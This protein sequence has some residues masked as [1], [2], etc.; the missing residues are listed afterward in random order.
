MKIKK[1]YSPIHLLTYSPKNG[2][3]IIEVVVVFLLILGVTFLVLPKSMNNTKQARFISKWSTK[4]S[5]LEYMYTVIKAQQDGQYLK[6][7]AKPKNNTPSNCIIPELFKP[8]LRITSEVQSINYNR[9]YMNKQPVGES[10]RYAFNKYYRTSDNEIMAMKWLKNDCTDDKNP[11]AIVSFDMNGVEPPNTWGYDIFGL[12]L[13]KN[14][15]QA[16]GQSI[17][18]DILKND[19]SKNG[20]GIYCSYYY[21]MGGRFD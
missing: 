8:Y 4:F 16:L 14:N 19:C 9:F 12:N 2:F 1:T 10:D 20:Y 5:E 7:L 18:P 11:C 13:F 6:E 3:T 21:L 15:I 17:Q